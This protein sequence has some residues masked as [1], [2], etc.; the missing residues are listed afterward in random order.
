V[1]GGVEQT[2]ALLNERFDYI[3]YTG[4][5]RVGRIVYEAAA[6][7]LTPVTLE[8]GG[9]SPVYL[10]DSVSDLEVAVKRILW[11][12]CMNS[13]QT[14]VAPDYILCE[15][16]LQDKIVKLSKKLL[17]GFY[18]NDA[19]KSSDFARIIND[20]NFNRLDEL[21][22]ATKGD[23]AVGGRRDAGERSIEPTVVTN[24]K[25]DDSLMKDE[26]S[27][28]YLWWLTLF[29]ILSGVNVIFLTSYNL[30]AVVDVILVVVFIV[31][32]TSSCTTH[33]T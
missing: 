6:K 3:F 14:C 30:F 27:T 28:V 19:I 8:L 12:K 5:T 20:G 13:G 7:N 32:N 11:G 33:P 31:T 17:K 16:S 21:L 10:D 22:N 29:P 25:G 26:V 23:I 9:K 24:V 18:G 1:S 15:P 4:S 2:T